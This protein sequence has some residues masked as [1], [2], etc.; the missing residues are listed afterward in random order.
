MSAEKDYDT[1][2]LATTATWLPLMQDYVD[3]AVCVCV[4]VHLFE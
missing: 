1:N 2:H 3:L 4:C